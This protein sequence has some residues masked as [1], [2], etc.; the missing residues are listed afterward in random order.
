MPETVQLAPETDER[1]KKIGNFK[2]RT[3][4]TFI[5]LAGY[6]TLLAMGHMYIIVLVT[7]VQIIVYKEVIALASVPAEEKKI[8]FFKVLNWYVLA[9]AIRRKAIA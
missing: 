6:I 1:R 9:P 5:L 4:W 8:P 2:E 3:L 7:I